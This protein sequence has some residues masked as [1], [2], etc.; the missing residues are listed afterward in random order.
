MGAWT[1]EGIQWAI[2]VLFSEEQ[3]VPANFYLGLAV[4]AIVKADT[5]AGNGVGWTE[6]TGT[7]Y[8]RVAIASS[9]VGWT[10]QTDGATGW[11]VVAAAAAVF[12]ATDTDWD[13]ALWWFL[14]TTIG[15]G[16]VL[17]AAGALSESRS[18]AVS[19]DHLDVTATLG[20][21]STWA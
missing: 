14:A 15:A 6:V 10:S 16:G 7:G 1:T 11:E 20:L 12:T 8:A 21:D 18:L 9:A 13:D 2:E 4:D 17:I 5:L 19:G 3:V